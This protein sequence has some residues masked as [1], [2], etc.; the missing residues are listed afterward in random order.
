MPRNNIDY[1]K[2]I[3]YKIV[4]KSLSVQEIYVGHTTDFTR[5]K[6]NH[7]KDSKETSYKLYKMIR[8]NGG[9]ENWDMVE[10]EKYPCT[11][12]N[13]ARVRERYYYDILSPNLNS[14]VPNRNMQE[15]IEDN[16]Q[17]IKEQRRRHYDQNKDSILK[18]DKIYKMNNIEKVKQRKIQYY[19]DNKEAI[20]EIKKTIM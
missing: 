8:D 5:R 16:K 11:D 14:C 19:N 4:C 18:K 3:I 2:T 1:S 17:N 20:L 12:G 7:K 9:W 6:N 13:E 15:W 10:I